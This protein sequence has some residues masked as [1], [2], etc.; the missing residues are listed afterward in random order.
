V[1]AI[2]T[3]SQVQGTPTGGQMLDES[4]SITGTDL[5]SSPPRTT[6]REL[7]R[8]LTGRETWTVTSR[9]GLDRSV[10]RGMARD[11]VKRNVVTLCGIPT[12]QIGPPSKSLDPAQARAVLV[13]AESS[14]LHAYEVLGNADRKRHGTAHLITAW[15]RGRLGPMPY[16]RRARGNR[17]RRRSH[18]YCALAVP[19]RPYE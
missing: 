8:R 11:K 10:S 17:K 12:G 13:A 5:G 6:D 15:H 1:P 14:N 2:E 16:C 4:A 18:G 3:T 19:L 7:H 9:D